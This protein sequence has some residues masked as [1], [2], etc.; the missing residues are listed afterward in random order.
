MT[1]PNTRGITERIVNSWMRNPFWQSTVNYVT[2]NRTSETPFYRVNLMSENNVIGQALIL[3]GIFFSELR[4]FQH[5]RWIIWHMFT[6]NFLCWKCT[7]T[8]NPGSLTTTLENIIYRWGHSNVY[9][10]ESLE[11]GFGLTKNIKKS[12]HFQWNGTKVSKFWRTI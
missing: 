10:W 11:T 9:E 3:F 1:S 5:M 7:A 8:K 2:T 6:Y 12:L 4:I